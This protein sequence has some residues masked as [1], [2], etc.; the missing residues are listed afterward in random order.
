MIG[1]VAFEH[2]VRFHI[3]PRGKLSKGM[4]IVLW[5]APGGE[6]IGIIYAPTRPGRRSLRLTRSPLLSSVQRA[7]SP[8]RSPLSVPTRRASSTENFSPDC[9]KFRPSARAAIT[10]CCAQDRH[11]CEDKE[12]RVA[13]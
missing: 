12:D 9:R 1:D 3:A 7:M 10:R 5:H 4:V 2:G 13:A 8:T 6:P 11:A